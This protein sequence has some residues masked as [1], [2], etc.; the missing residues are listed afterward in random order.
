MTQTSFLLSGVSSGKAPVGEGKAVLSPEVTEK[1][2]E[3]FFA[4]LAQLV[5]GDGDVAQAVADGE[6]V[7]EGDAASEEAVSEALLKS[8]ASEEGEDGENLA[9]EEAAVE[10]EAVDPA[11][12]AKAAISESEANALMSSEESAEEV[13]ADK[14]QVAKKDGEALLQRLNESSQA[15]QAKAPKVTD[16]KAVEAA[17]ITKS[18]KNLPLNEEELVAANV[19][20]GKADV[21]GENNVPARDTDALK[22]KPLAVNVPEEEAALLGAKAQTNVLAPEVKAN[23][24]A[25]ELAPED[26]SKQIE[27]ALAAK[28]AQL[29]QVENPETARTAEPVS[30]EQLAVMQTNLQAEKQDAPTSLDSAVM[31]GAIPAVANNA[32]MPTE[33]SAEIELT[34]EMLAKAG[35]APETLSRAQREALMRAQMATMQSAA[36]T[37]EQALANTLA[38]LGAK[39]LTPQ[40]QAAMT[41][42]ATAVQAAVNAQ[43]QQTTPLSA[44]AAIPWTPAAAMPQVNGQ[45]QPAASQAIIEAAAAKSLTETA[46]AG[47]EVKA[48]N[49]AQ[50]LASSFGQQG[51]TTTAAKLDTAMAQT[52]LQM[53][54]NQAEA[55]NALSERVNM[56]MSKNLKHVDIRLD[57]PELGRM[58]IKLSMNNDQATVQFT[59][60]NQAARD[61]VEQSMPRLREMMQQQ[62]LQL[63]QSSVQQQDAGGRQAFNG[64]QAQTGDGQQGGQH[65]QSDGSRSGWG[66]SEQDSEHLGLNR[67]LYVNTSKDRVD[68]YA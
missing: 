66:D 18:G 20:A 2:G 63:A 38:E 19:G 62:G 22:D 33:Q 59:V 31:S 64:Q 17:K 47:G 46:Q 23:A 29:A 16:E 50:Q 44:F 43:T 58:Q 52:P 55:A 56:M 30:P 48:E 3:G 35:I 9:L 24:D 26:G 11:K 61:M 4:Q 25:D 10:G 12:V 57:P 53:S 65:S 37:D 39:G 36:P 14:Q 41:Q 1:E 60:S 27:P 32:T 51:S 54:Q 28:Y 5:S 15:L 7:T 67:E 40:S 42:T 8:L 13:P 34:P 45:L 21:K 68:Y 6:L 49:L